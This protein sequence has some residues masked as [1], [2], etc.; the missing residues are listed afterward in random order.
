MMEARIDLSKYKVRTDLAIEA[1]EMV[2]TSQVKE[3]PKQ[4][5]IR[6]T[7]EVSEDVKIT[8]VVIDE[9]GEKRIG[10][11]QGK[12]VT[13]EMEALRT[14][15]VEAQERFFQVLKKQLSEMLRYM[16][17]A[18]DSDVFVVG[19][20][21][22]DV[23]PDAIGPLVVENLQITRHLFELQPW[24]L[25]AGMRAVSAM[26]PGVMGMTGI[27]T[28]D[29][30]EAVV[31]KTCPSLIV[32]VDALA[33]R[34]LNR[35]N[36]TLQMTDTGIQPGSG[37]GNQRKELSKALYGVPVLAIGV[38]TVV[39]AVA[40]TS[41]TVDYML[42]HFGREM[43]EGDKPSHALVPSGMHFGK[44]K[45]FGQEDEL[46]TDR[47][48]TYM[49]LIGVLDENEKRKLIHEVLSSIGLNLMVT[50]KEVDQYV[51]NMAELI[52][53]ALNEV[54]HQSA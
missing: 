4:T 3:E 20:G 38:P 21:N 10:K 2:N 25:Q 45:S 23:T 37:V 32:V 13:L 35:V 47:K 14:E 50:P 42:K 51:R 31:Q 36:T 1:N 8:T 18:P 48:Q 7:E 54:L 39:D 29:M 33:A 26:I 53:R 12:Y 49:G 17:I 43:H 44:R 52:A 41:D 5:G 6:L 46:P 34:S 22:R 28:S 15:E 19:L 11:T 30:I 16:Q 24:S 40:I 27:E 9:V